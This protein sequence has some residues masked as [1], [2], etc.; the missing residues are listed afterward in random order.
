MEQEG[1]GCEARGR[2]EVGVYIDM[3]VGQEVGLDRD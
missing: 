1:G 3:L 2:L